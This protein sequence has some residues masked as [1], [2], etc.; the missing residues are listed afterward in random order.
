MTSN[1]ANLLVEIE[2]LKAVK[3]T[4][5]LHFYKKSTLMVHEVIQFGHDFEDNVEHTA[6]IFNSK[7]KLIS[8]KVS[9]FSLKSI[10]FTSGRRLL[11][12]KASVL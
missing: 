7:S 2:Y 9:A 3:L 5:E 4:E 12:M 6:N 8:C 11:L 10:S 1:P